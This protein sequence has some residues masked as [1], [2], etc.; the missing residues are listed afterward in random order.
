MWEASQLGDLEDLEVLGG[1]EGQAGLEG[2]EPQASLVVHAILLPQAFLPQ[3][4]QED[5]VD[6]VLLWGLGSQEVQLDHLAPQ[7]L[8]FQMGL[9][10]PDLLGFLVPL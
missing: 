4:T 2:P 10:N 5:L 1:L 7:F 8:E 9:V 6:L 3:G